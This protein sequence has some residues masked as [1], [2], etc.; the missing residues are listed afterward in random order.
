MDR[1]LLV[2]LLNNQKQRLKIKVDSNVIFYVFN[3]EFSN[4]LD[5]AIA[6]KELVS[7][8]YGKP[9]YKQ[10]NDKQIEWLKKFYTPIS[11]ELIDAYNDDENLY[12]LFDNRTQE[13]FVRTKDCKYFSSYKLALQRRLLI[14]IPELFTKKPIYK[15]TR[16]EHRWIKSYRWL[17]YN[18][19]PKI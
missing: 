9:I 14:S 15:L 1:Q 5:Q 6:N 7:I 4:T 12:I 16:N 18:K 17:I 11:G 2:T 3:D 13:I 8:E 19:L 10:L